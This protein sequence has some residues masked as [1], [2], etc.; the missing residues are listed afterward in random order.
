MSL[1]LRVF[2]TAYYVAK[3]NKPF[4]DFES[5]IDLQHANSADLGRVLQSKTVYVDIIDHM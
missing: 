1:Y 2:R 3:S 4:T 5:M